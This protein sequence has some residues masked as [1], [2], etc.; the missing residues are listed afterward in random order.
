MFREDGVRAFVV[1]RQF[2]GGR[3]Q[4]S[5]S[6][7]TFY[8]CSPALRAPRRFEQGAPFTRETLSGFK[9]FGDRL[10]FVAHS[11]GVQSGAETEVGWVDFRI[12]RVRSGRINASEGLQN[13]SEEE[14]GLPRV[15]AGNVHYAIAGDGTVAVLGEGGDPTEWEVCLLPVK[16]HSLGPPRPLFIAKPGQEGLDPHSLAITDTSVTWRMK[17]GQPASA[18]R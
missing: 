1:V 6:Y 10:G 9:I 12:G 13:E 11:E 4:S 17:N 7:K 3:G 14:P 5:S 16:L 15:P 8:I 2:E 18:P